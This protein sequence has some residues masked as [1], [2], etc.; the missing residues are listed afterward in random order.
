MFRNLFSCLGSALS[1]KSIAGSAANELKKKKG[2]HFIL[3]NKNGIFVAKRFNMLLG[4]CH[5]VEML[6]LKFDMPNAL[7]GT[8]D[9][10][11]EAL[12]VFEMKN[13]TFR[14]RFHVLPNCRQW[15]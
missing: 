8:T 15:A 1:T 5:F 4:Q 13:K 14:A 12:M 6:I 11:D 3:L 2:K 10:F 7:N 9:I